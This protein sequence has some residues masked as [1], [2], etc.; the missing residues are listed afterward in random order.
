[1]TGWSECSIRLSG[2]GHAQKDVIPDVTPHG[3]ETDQMRNVVPDAV[4]TEIRIATWT[5]PVPRP[6]P[7]VLKALPG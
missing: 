7:A 5:F 3:N 2:A 4:A 6:L 1:M